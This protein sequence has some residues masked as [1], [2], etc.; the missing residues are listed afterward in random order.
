MTRFTEIRPGV[1]AHAGHENG[2]QAEYLKRYFDDVAIANRRGRGERLS[3]REWCRY[4]RQCYSGWKFRRA[5]RRIG[6]MNRPPGW[7]PYRKR[8]QR[9]KAI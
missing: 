8:N 6:A 3:L 1:Y 4:A 9:S 2:A 7:L 5:C